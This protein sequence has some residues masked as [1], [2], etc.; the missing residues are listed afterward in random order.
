MGKGKK[1]V[2]KRVYKANTK[3]IKKL[4]LVVIAIF[5]VLILVG[6]IKNGVTYLYLKTWEW[7]TTEEYGIKYKLPRAFEEVKTSVQSSL[8]SSAVFTTDTEVKV[9]EKYVSKTSDI[10]YSGGNRLNGILLMLQCLKTEKT[11]KSLDEIAEG[12]HIL[13]TLNYEKNYTVGEMQKEEVEVLGIQS[14]R[15]SETLTKVDEEKMIVSYL[16]PMDDEEVTI[17]FFGD[18]ENMIKEDSEIRK[19]VT[20]MQKI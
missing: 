4:L 1:T 18:K 7:H 12:Q 9:N 17:I 14:V 19:I 10:V 8:L 20:Q 2:E 15:I 11:N 16:V 6:P 5:I 3:A 13:V